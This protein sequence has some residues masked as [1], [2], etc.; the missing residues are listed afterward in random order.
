MTSA[1]MYMVLGEDWS[2]FVATIKQ[3]LLELGANL[4]DTSFSIL[5]TD[6]SFFAVCGLAARFDVKEFA[7]DTCIVPVTNSAQTLGLSCI[8]ERI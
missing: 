8:V 2:G 5:S 3:C 1:A 4:T 6:V 7:S